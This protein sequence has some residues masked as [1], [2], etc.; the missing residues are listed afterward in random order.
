MPRRR[1]F[2]VSGTA[3]NTYGDCLNTAREASKNVLSLDSPAQCRII[4]DGRS[5]RL[6]S[7]SSRMQHTSCFD[8]QP[9]SVLGSGLGPPEVNIYLR[10]KKTNR[11]SL[12]Q[13]LFSA[14]ARTGG[15]AIHSTVLSVASLKLTTSDHVAPSQPDRVRS[16]RSSHRE[17]TPK[18]LSEQQQQ[19][20][21]GLGHID[22][23]LA[24]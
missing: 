23:A 4:D 19:H 22:L 18:G 24:T 5:Y 2:K 7:A 3:D 8:S 15:G 14:I 9:G 6:P 21:S 11:P 20:R 10:C 13:G 1:R 12:R 17:A 16:S